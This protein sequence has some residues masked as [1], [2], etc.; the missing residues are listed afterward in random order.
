MTDEII[1][2]DKS[3]RPQLAG[4]LATVDFDNISGPILVSAYYKHL[5]EKDDESRKAFYNLFR[6][7]LDILDLDPITYTIIAQ[8]KKAHFNYITINRF[9]H[10]YCIKEHYIFFNF[11]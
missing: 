7:G 3:I 1:R 11:R 6:Q 5:T 8:N 9:K 4:E 2:I 10:F